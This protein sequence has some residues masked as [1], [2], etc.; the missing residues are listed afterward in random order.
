MNN[1]I[2]MTYKK[3]VPD[4]VFDRWKKYNPDYEVDFSLDEDCILFLK[5]HFNDYVA[6]LFCSIKKGMFKADL[7]R[8]CKL[9]V[10]GGV[11][12]DV[13]LVPYLNLDFL[14]KNISFYSCLA[15]DGK[16][17]F[18]A[19][20]INFSKPKNP[21]IFI[22]LLSFLLNNSYVFTNGP[23]YD[24]FN[25][26]KYNLNNNPSIVS[27]KKYELDEVK[28]NIKI[29]PSKTN[30]KEINLYYFPEEINYTLKIKE[31][32]FDDLFDL[33]INNN[34]LTVKRLDANK[35]WCHSHSVDVCISSKE[36]IFLF[37]EKYG[38]ESKI[39]STCYV[40]FNSQ[41]ILDSRDEEYFKKKGW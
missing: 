7:W 15:V 18:Q 30:I 4:K 3:P 23:T 29:G 25:C 31:H 22:F 38:N 6:N 1:K 37:Q 39:I 13:D 17:I 8:L 10:H 16:S 34:I 2:Y 26:L 35:G 40:E 20:M 33:T 32:K 36:S 27:E 19:I 5:Q 11:Y 12:A 24:M 9:Y 14:D 41:K 21:L 28:I